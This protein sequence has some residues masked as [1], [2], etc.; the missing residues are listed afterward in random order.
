MSVSFKSAGFDVVSSDYNAALITLYRAVKAGWDPPKTLSR[1]EYQLAKSLPDADPLKAF[2][3]FGCSFG[4]KWFGGYA[5]GYNG[6]LTYPELARRNVLRSVGKL[7]HIL[8]LSFLD[9]SSTASNSLIYC[10]PPYANTT[11]YSATGEFNTNAFWLRVQQ[12]EACGVPVYVSEYVCPLPHRIVWERASRG[13]LGLAS[14]KKHTEKL[15]R[16]T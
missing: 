6:P 10:D 14:G 2:A 7:E 3:G 15:V 11:R 13:T 5:S 1:A 9:V 16:L 12:W 4:G 8:H